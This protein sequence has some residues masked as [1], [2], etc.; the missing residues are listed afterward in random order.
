MCFFSRLLSDTPGEILTVTDAFSPLKKKITITVNIVTAIPCLQ[1]MV[2]KPVTVYLQWLYIHYVYYQ[3]SNLYYLNQ[4]KYSIST[5]TFGSNCCTE[6][7]VNWT[8]YIPITAEVDEANEMPAYSNIAVTYGTKLGETHSHLIP[9]F[10]LNPSKYCIAPSLS[11]LSH[12]SQ[13]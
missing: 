11:T 12:K 9:G 4:H 13:G 6:I 3:I 10:H 7:C 1:L 5:L 2:L 8:A